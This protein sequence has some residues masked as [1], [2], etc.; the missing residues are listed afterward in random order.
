MLSR[1]RRVFALSKETIIYRYLCDSIGSRFGGSPSATVW[2]KNAFCQ[3]WMCGDAYKW[4]NEYVFWP[5]CV[6][7]LCQNSIKS[8]RIHSCWP[9]ISI[10]KKGKKRKW[11]EVQPNRAEGCAWRSRAHTARTFSSAG[12][13]T[14]ELN[15][16]TFPFCP[17]EAK[18]FFLFSSLLPNVTWNLSHRVCVSQLSHWITETHVS[19]ERDNIQSN[20]IN[21]RRFRTSISR[22][23]G[24]CVHTMCVHR[25]CH[26]HHQHHL[27]R[28][29]PRI[30]AR[31]EPLK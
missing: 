31:P 19:I 22:K 4:M 18:I 27:S 14:I 20:Q 16:V 26:H 10:D 17:T 21:C 28:R 12:N 6:Y 1:H 29:S 15:T 25:V 5:Y 24:L 9:M 23:T 2:G 7:T 30:R 11:N 3:N 13:E 8:N